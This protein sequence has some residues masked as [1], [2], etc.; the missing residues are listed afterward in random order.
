VAEKL[1]AFLSRRAAKVRDVSDKE[2]DAAVDEAV[3]SGPQ[4]SDQ[5]IS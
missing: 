3:Y 5:T 1:E 2:L 4:I